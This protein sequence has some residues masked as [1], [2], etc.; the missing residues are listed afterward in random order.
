M[1]PYALGAQEDEKR[2]LN[3]HHVYEALVRGCSILSPKYM[4]KEP[5]V[6]VSALEE[7][8]FTN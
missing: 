1:E 8:K 4:F 5:G 3:P 6:T 2:G 7:K